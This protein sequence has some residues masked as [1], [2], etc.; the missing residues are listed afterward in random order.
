MIGSDTDG[1]LADNEL[2]GEY[3]NIKILKFWNKHNNIYKISKREVQRDREL[4]F[5]LI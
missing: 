1:T 5:V 4:F 3:F 2:P